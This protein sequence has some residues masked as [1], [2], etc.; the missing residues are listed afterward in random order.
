MPRIL[1]NKDQS[2]SGQSGSVLHFVSLNLRASVILASLLL[3]HTGWNVWRTATN[4]PAIDFF[5]FWS[6]PHARAQQPIADIYSTEGQNE[7]GQAMAVEARAHPPWILQRQAT[8]AVLQLYGGR[9]DVTGSPL[10]YT[11]IGWISSGDY[12]T[13]QRRFVLLCTT[14]L[15]ISVLVFCYLL[16]F[17]ITATILLMMFL[18]WDYQPV[19]ADMRVGNVNQILLLAV[20][21]FI[22]LVSRSRPLTAGVV[23]GAAAMFKPT[24]GMI[25]VLAVILGV[26]DREYRLLFRMLLGGAV[27]AIT[28]FAVSLSTFGPRDWTHF[29]TSLPKTLDGRSYPLDHGNFS[30]SALL[31]GVTSG[32]SAIIP[33]LGIAGFTWL[34]FATR[35]R[36][37]SALG[38]APNIAGSRLDNAFAMGGGGCAI[39]L[40]V[41]PLVWLHYYLLLIP[42]SLYVIRPIP[43]FGLTPSVKDA[44]MHAAPFVPLAMFSVLNEL[45]TGNDAWRASLLVN[46]ATVLTLGIASF[47]FWNRRRMMQTAELSGDG[48]PL[49][50]VPP[51][52]TLAKGAQA[53]HVRTKVNQVRHRSRSSNA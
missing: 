21:L 36:V 41:S 53:S 43:N 22:L 23:V 46:V 7:M 5:T 34:V 6:V 2:P 47:Q 25:V 35:S 29:L 24:V 11:V 48:E 50:G 10:L 20:A 32:A 44:V 9:I 37:D 12:E 15:A 8:G 45:F 13:D 38:D 14:S 4:T 49:P 39:L 1:E 30:L 27:G 33:A 42:L 3:I 52:A 16:K 51:H 26:A 19:L 31:F 18:S 28:A 40:L 17:S